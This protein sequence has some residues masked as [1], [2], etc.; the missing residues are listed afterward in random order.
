VAPEERYAALAAT[1]ADD[2]DVTLPGPGGGFGASALKA[3]GRIF[4]MLVGGELVV[5]LPRARVEALVASGDG[6]AFR[7]G[8]RVLREWVTVTAP[9][10]WDELVAEARASAGSRR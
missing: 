3:G 6:A 5:K 7:S 8:G 9:Q 10:R 2:P 1:Y 4:A